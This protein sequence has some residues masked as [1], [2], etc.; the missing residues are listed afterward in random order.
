MRVKAE[1]DMTETK[2]QQQHNIITY[3]FIS[4]AAQRQ[5]TFRTFLSELIRKKQTFMFITWTTSFSE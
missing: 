4:F 1:L 2:Q 3:I 5:C